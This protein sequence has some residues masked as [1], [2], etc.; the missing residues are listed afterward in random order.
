MFYFKILIIRLGK[1]KIKKKEYKILY[2]QY[3][4]LIIEEQRPEIIKSIF[5]LKINFT[6][7]I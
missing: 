2:L 7:L 4:G 1:K 3:R 5:G 6:S